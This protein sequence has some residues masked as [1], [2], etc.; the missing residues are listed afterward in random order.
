MK[1]KTLLSTASCLFLIQFLTFTSINASKIICKPNM[2]LSCDWDAHLTKTNFSSTWMTA[3]GNMPNSMLPTIVGS[4]PLHSLQ[5]RDVGTLSTCNIGTFTRHFRINGEPYVSCSMQITFSGSPS[6]PVL[7]W[8][9]DMHIWHSPTL[10]EADVLE[11]TVRAR[12]VDQNGG[13]GPTGTNLINNEQTNNPITTNGYT[14]ESSPLT[15]SLREQPRFNNRYKNVGC[16]VFGRKIVITQY[17]VSD[18]CRK[19][20]VSFQNINWCTNSSA[21]C[22][23]TVYKY[24]SNDTPIITLCDAP[25]VKFLNSDCL[26]ETELKPK[27]TSTSGIDSD[28]RWRVNIYLNNPNFTISS[29]VSHTYSTVG[30]VGGSSAI[31]GGSP[32]I[33]LT[34]S[35]GLP[36]GTHGLKYIVSNAC[37]NVE[38]CDTSIVVWPKVPTPICISLASAVM[39]NGKL[40]LW[41]K[42]FD[43]KSIGY[44]GAKYL[45]FTFNNERPVDSKIKIEH[46][47][48]G[49]GLNATK[50]EYDEGLAQLW[51]PQISI[52]PRPN[53]PNGYPDP[54]GPDTT[55]VGGQSSKAFG[56]KVGDGSS[57][58]ESDVRMTVWDDKWASDFCLVKISFIDNQNACDPPPPPPPPPVDSFVNLGGKV[59][60]QN[61]EAF[62]NVAV[63]LSSNQPE[64]P[65]V[66][67]SDSLGTFLFDYLPTL[68][69]YRIT[70]SYDSDFM[71]GVNTA[72]M[73]ALLKHILDIEPIEGVL[74]LE[75][76][77]INGD[78]FVELDDLK[79]LMEA[80]MGA[81]DVSDLASWRFID[82]KQIEVDSV[83][84]INRFIL[85]N[86]LTQTIL[87][88]E[89]VA[90]KIGDIVGPL[91]SQKIELEFRAR[92]KTH[93][94][95]E[96]LHVRKGQKVD[97]SFVLDQKLVISGLQFAL[98]HANLELIGVSSN[99]L[100]IDPS[101]Y[102]DS[103]N[104]LKLVF[105]AA[106]VTSINE[107]SEIVKLTFVAKQSG[108]L[109]DLIS[110]DNASLSS[111][112][113]SGS[114][115]QR[116]I[117]LRFLEASEAE[118]KVTNHPNPWS[119]ST[120]IQF[121][122]KTSG[123]A[124]LTIF[125][126]DGKT[127]LNNTMSLEKGLNSIDITE[128]DLKNINGIL[129]YKITQGDKV[130]VGKMLKV[131]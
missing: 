79:L 22:R 119:V 86:S 63:K 8:P 36:P 54:R 91:E 18:A 58:P 84:P 107:G 102:F 43:F 72:D 67:N 27:A 62:T 5:F 33:Y 41:A 42:H 47:F 23:E 48:K 68:K 40:D 4:Y 45:L 52:K 129:M 55:L 15:E 121:V 11:N 120:Q 66:V 124:N 82:K 64:Y 1:L 44:C 53:M 116:N 92:E 31:A 46:Y 65:F 101:N 105:G 77:D 123:E 61:G 89:L 39:K 34:G 103:G 7:E 81:I 98:T 60:Y 69:E 87:D 99:S 14:P 125:D 73:I 131:Q 94:I 90:V 6:S 93:L 108:K 122:A 9:I 88:N 104:L 32:T 112:V 97:V 35:R 2:T 19:W 126:V 78:G 96:D 57:F 85:H 56:C 3:S 118:T 21:G 110:I 111:S 71:E 74:K 130:E 25:K 10:T 113:F 115:E 70:A 50:A 75:A 114:L 37:G 20:V 26:G 59:F 83:W 24:E 109:S 76:A 29:P 117:G 106:N 51:F 28:L 17:T 80:I 127:V 38:E 49:N 100:A 30:G 12:R 95:V 16:N 13:C 128:N